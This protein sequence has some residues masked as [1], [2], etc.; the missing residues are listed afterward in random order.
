MN[1]TIKKIKSAL[2]RDLITNQEA[3][4]ACMNIT[5]DRLESTD[6]KADALEFMLEIVEAE[7]K[8]VL[9]SAAEAARL[10]LSIVINPGYSKESR[11]RS[12]ESLGTR[13][14]DLEELI[15]RGV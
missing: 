8:R 6:K 14:D 10:S 7:R 2:E 5:G 15:E 13:L 11:M 12:L 1:A 9:A 3:M 4:N